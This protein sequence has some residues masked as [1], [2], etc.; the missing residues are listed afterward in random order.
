[1]KTWTLYNLQQAKKKYSNNVN[2]SILVD[3]LDY[4]QGL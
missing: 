2:V 3:N 1:M 4:Q